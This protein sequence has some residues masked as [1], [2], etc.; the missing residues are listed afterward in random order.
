MSGASG[1]VSCEFSP[2]AVRDF[3]QIDLGENVTEAGRIAQLVPEG[4]D[5]EERHAK[6]AIVHSILEPPQGLVVPSE[7]VKKE[8]FHGGAAATPPRP[9]SREDPLGLGTST[10]ACQGVAL[11]KRGLR[12]VGPVAA[13]K[14]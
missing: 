11:V 6:R 5:A 10:H 12:E 3:E 2:H 4:I 7:R 14:L 8:S 13:T 9:E 1:P